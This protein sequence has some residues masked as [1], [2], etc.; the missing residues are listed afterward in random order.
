[1][2]LRRALVAA[3]CVLLLAGC[4]GQ[5][6]RVPAPQPSPSPEAFHGVE[7][8][9]VPERPEFVLRTTSGERYSFQERT[10]GRPTLLYFGYTNCPDECP[11]RWPTSRRRCGPRP[12][13]CATTSRSCS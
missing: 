13:T 10:G 2:P 3:A 12:P 6:H 7:P 5:R 9:P 1:M 4:A 11:P 8:D